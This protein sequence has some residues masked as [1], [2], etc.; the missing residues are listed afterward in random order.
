MR[1]YEY[2]KLTINRKR[3]QRINALSAS[4]RHFEKFLVMFC[5]F[6]DIWTKT[7]ERLLIG[8]A[9]WRDHLAL[10]LN[11]GIFR[12]VNFEFQKATHA[13][14]FC[15]CLGVSRPF[16]SDT[17]PERIDREGLRKRHTVTRQLPTDPFSES[18]INERA[19]EEVDRSSSPTSTKTSFVL[20]NDHWSV[21]KNSKVDV[22]FVIWRGDWRNATSEYR[23]QNWLLSQM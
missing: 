13:R 23:M 2:C 4:V 1:N 6:V 8:W 15:F 3:N 10:S 14:T 19:R 18:M 21:N 7:I 16:A 12:T 11:L 9:V 20:T 5:C 17:S 22:E